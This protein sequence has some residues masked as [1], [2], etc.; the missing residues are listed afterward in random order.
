MACDFAQFPLSHPQPPFEFHPDSRSGT[1]P[2]VS[3]RVFCLPLVSP[4]GATLRCASSGGELRWQGAID[5][6]WSDSA[7]V[8]YS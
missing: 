4:S 3:K 1:R 5:T 8:M 7:I 6:K 2:G